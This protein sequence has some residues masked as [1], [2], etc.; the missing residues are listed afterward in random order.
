MFVRNTIVSTINANSQWLS[1]VCESPVATTFQNQFVRPVGVRVLFT[2]SQRLRHTHTYTHT[3]NIKWIRV[4]C[5]TCTRNIVSGLAAGHRFCVSMPD[6]RWGIC[7]RCQTAVYLDW[8][9]V[10]DIRTIPRIRTEFC[11][12]LSVVCLCLCMCVYVCV[13]RSVLARPFV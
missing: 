9:D 3:Q 4:C 10:R 8:M 7:L 11:T 6:A 12:V 1:R 13:C 2:D 5:C